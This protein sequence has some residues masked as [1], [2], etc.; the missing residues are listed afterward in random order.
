MENTSDKTAA[1]K[2]VKTLKWGQGDSGNSNGSRTGFDKKIVETKSR[3]AYG[4]TTLGNFEDLDQ[5]FE[6]DSQYGI[7]VNISFY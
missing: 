4:S 2:S 6:S 5:G 7:M 1:F 3:Y